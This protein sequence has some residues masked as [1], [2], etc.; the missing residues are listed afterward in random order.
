TR[1]K[2]TPGMVISDARHMCSLFEILTLCPLQFPVLFNSCI[3][4]DMHLHL[5]QD[6]FSC[7]SRTQNR[8][9]TTTEMKLAC[10]ANSLNPDRTQPLIHFQSSEQADTRLQFTPEV[11]TGTN[12]HEFGSSVN[13]SY[14]GMYALYLK[15]S[16]M[17]PTNW[18]Y[19]VVSYAITTLKTQSRVTGI[20]D[21]N[22]AFPFPVI[23]F[24]PSCTTKPFGRGSSSLDRSKMRKKGSQIHQEANTP[25]SRV[26]NLNAEQNKQIKLIRKIVLIM[27][28]VVIITGGSGRRARVEAKLAHG[29]RKA[30]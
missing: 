23:F 3:A 22:K 28:K 8:G 30:G 21:L 14:S 29:N 19:N 20:M 6:A 5:Y 2:S 12:G 17:L 16:Y 18:K 4:S 11:V 15:H 13:G 10:P 27:G 1:C 24:L 9:C 7:D 26:A 25:H